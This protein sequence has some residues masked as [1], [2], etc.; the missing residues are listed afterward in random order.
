MAEKE[1][2]NEINI[3][4][5]SIGILKKDME[6]LSTEAYKPQR[7]YLPIGI[8]LREKQREY[9]RI[10]A[11]APVGVQFRLQNSKKTHARCTH[12]HHRI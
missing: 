5:D 1:K 6:T 2:I 8:H 12:P 7:L 9:Q 10:D 3:A 11:Q 4:E